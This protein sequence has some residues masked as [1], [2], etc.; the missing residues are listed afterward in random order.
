M[1]Q[2]PRLFH[3]SHEPGIRLFEPRPVPNA[4]SSATGLMVW[5]IDEDHIQNYLL[6]RDCPRVTFFANQT[7]SCTDVAAL[8]GPSG[9]RHVIAVEACW[10]SRIQSQRLVRYEFD[11]SPFELH[12]AIAGYWTSRTPVE[13]ITE[14]P[15]DDIL[16]ELLKQDIELRVM[17]SLWKLREAV[18]HS[19]LGF[20]IIRMGNAQPPPEGLGAYYP[21]A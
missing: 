13:P 19:S 3:I 18:I 9:A 21:L 20:S 8:L 11:P 1:S 4:S 16:A 2:K 6:P 7:S 14:A 10:L 17:H 15:I 5:A 12:D